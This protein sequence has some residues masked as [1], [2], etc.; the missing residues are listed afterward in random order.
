LTVP[1][2]PDL[3]TIPT[4]ALEQP[5]DSTLLLTEWSC[6]TSPV[7]G[8]GNNPQQAL[9]LLRQ[10]QD[11]PDTSVL[12]V[13]Q[14]PL[15]NLPTV[16]HLAL[17]HNPQV[18]A[19]W[20]TIAQQAAQL[21]QAHSAYWPQLSAGVAR[22]RSR[23]GY[24]GASVSAEAIWATRQ[25]AVASW[26]L[27][28]F[29]ARSA[30]ADAAR[31][32]LQAAMRT[33]DAAV[34]KVLTDV[35]QTYGDAQAAQARLATQISLLPLAERSVQAAQRREREG[36]GSS[37]DVL[38]AAAA[39]ARVNLELSRSQGERDKAHAQLTYLIGLPPGT[40]YRTET[41]EPALQ[42][43]SSVRQPGINSDL[44][45]LLARSLDE[46]LA[47]ATQSHPAI[48]A[49]KAQLQAAQASLK[50][51]QSEGLPTIDLNLAH[52]RNGRPDMS[53]TDSR[54]NES[55]IGLTFSIPLFDGFASTYKVRAAQA[56]VEQKTIELQATE[57]QS[58]QEI[59]QLY[60]EAHASLD[61]L[62]AARSLYTASSQ[63]AQSS[64]RQYELGA[65][66]IVQLNQSLTNLQQAQLELTRSHTDWNKARLR[67]WL[68]ETLPE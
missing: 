11:N 59:V 68:N 3:L 30:R 61:N 66:D 47:Q 56:L 20:S 57:Q 14:P 7:A 45:R 2:P 29:G 24:A 58:L 35:L 18:R 12:A 67:L 42:A 49:A 22:Q 1:L 16:I 63:A 26:R 36:A 52:Y 5:P 17:C 62:Q 50:A 54:S 28:D 4:D 27:W 55:V 34:R 31:A 39:L 41:I 15:L 43:A 53:I 33:Q 6:A 51:V 8:S 40:A 9:V 38:Q 32:Q 65:A 25:Y 23:I 48:L 37:N 13:D 19:T 60:A 10:A 21:G 44:Y 46:W 64:Q